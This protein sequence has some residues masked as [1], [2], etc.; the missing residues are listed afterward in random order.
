MAERSKQD[1]EGLSME[2]AYKCYQ[3]EVKKS[4]ALRKVI[5]TV[6]ERARKA[7]KEK[8]EVQQKL[9]RAL[10]AENQTLLHL[11][12]YQGKVMDLVKSSNQILRDWVD[13]C[14]DILPLR[15][16]IADCSIW[17]E[18]ANGQADANDNNDGKDDNDDKN[19]KMETD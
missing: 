1:F 14:D 17:N 18:E 8:Q 19:D 11:T 2:Q 5:Q 4:N 9:K 16:Q 12:E 15:M 3:M 7:D 13:L 10:T 6:M